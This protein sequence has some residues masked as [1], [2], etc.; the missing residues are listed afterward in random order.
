MDDVRVH[1]NSPEPAKL[2]AFAYAKGSDIHL[3]PGQEQHLPHE[4]W[5]VV[6]QKQGRV[7]A[8]GDLGHG[9]AINSDRSLEQEADRLGARAARAASAPIADYE[10]RASPTVAGH[11]IQGAWIADMMRY[12]GLWAPER[13]IA[14]EMA[15]LRQTEATT[16]DPLLKRLLAE[17]TSLNNVNFSSVA[18]PEIAHAAR[19]NVGDRTQHEVNL[20]PSV[21]DATTRQSLLLHELIHVSAD[22]EYSADTIGEPDPALTAVLDP[23][24]AAIQDPVE[25]LRQQRTIIGEQN[26]YRYGLA[27]HLDKVVDGDFI[28]PDNLAAFVKGRLQRIMGASHREFDSVI[29]EV[30]FI[31]KK[32][33]LD[34][35]CDTFKEVAAMA[36]AAYQSRNSGVPLD[37]VYREPMKSGLLG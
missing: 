29:T 23:A 4:A 31:L 11:V 5:H 12:L 21:T 10:T 14:D 26:R 8:T 30:Y 32:N 22:R 37:R 15:A 3:G 35:R 24:H 19:V 20:D 25:R 34:E 28:I 16:D 2:G 17:A 13:T 1:R 36:A 9:L 6:Q 7:N 27:A 33:N 18:D